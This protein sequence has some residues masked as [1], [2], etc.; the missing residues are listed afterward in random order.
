M[1]TP[2]YNF[3]MKHFYE[4][5]LIMSAISAFSALI[6]IRANE[7]FKHET[8]LC[9]TEKRKSI[10]CH[11]VETAFYDNFELFVITF[12]SSFVAYTSVYVLTGYG[13]KQIKD[14]K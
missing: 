1:I 13:Y 14:Y 6:A 5:F 9:K 10:R 8:N 3:K 4:E 11:L 12:I 2:L 7:H